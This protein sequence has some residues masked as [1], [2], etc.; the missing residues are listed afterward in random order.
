[1][2]NRI[3]VFKQMLE[4]DPN[5]AMVLF[6]LANE[7]LKA[8]DYQN[9]IRT[10]E[11]YLQKADD[12]GAAYG[13]LAKAYERIGER[14]NARATYEK[15][16]AVSNTHGHPSMAHDYQTTLDLDYAE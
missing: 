3:E 6:G 11:S 10:L 7:Y 14:E 16:I 15:G 8:E 4:S 2:T 5:N 9:A 13:M 1:M 12:E